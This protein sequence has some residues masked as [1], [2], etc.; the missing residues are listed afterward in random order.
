MAPLMLPYI[1]RSGALVQFALKEILGK[2]FSF[3]HD[4]SDVQLFTNDGKRI[5]AYGDKS[6]LNIKRIFGYISTTIG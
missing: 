5:I 6:S 2:K 4:V 3:L 1:I